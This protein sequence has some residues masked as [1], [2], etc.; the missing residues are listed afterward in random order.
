MNIVF[1]DFYINKPVVMYSIIVV[2][3]F[4]QYP[5]SV[6][7]R[8]SDTIFTKYII[9]IMLQDLKSDTLSMSSEGADASQD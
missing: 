9:Q 8:V 4:H 5:L 6:L 1:T 7:L 3:Q 2:F